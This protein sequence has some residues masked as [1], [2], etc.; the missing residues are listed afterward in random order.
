M[1]RYG[2]NGSIFFDLIRRSMSLDR[3]FYGLVG[4]VLTLDNASTQGLKAFYLE[5]PAS[6]H[7]AWYEKGA[8]H[9]NDQEN[10]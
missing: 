1:L 5:E 6:Q 10:S 4:T 9:Q 2:Q 7:H 8:K 3:F